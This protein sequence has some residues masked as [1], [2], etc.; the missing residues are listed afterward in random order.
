M[1]EQEPLTPEWAQ[2]VRDELEPGEELVWAVQPLPV[3]AGRTVRDALP[4][5][6]FGLFWLGFT[7]FGY[8]M[9][10]SHR[11][12]R[13][14]FDDDFE[15]NFQGDFFRAERE[16]RRQ[17]ASQVTAF[18][19]VPLV[20]A[21]GAGLVGVALLLSPL[22]MTLVR[23]RRQEQSCYALTTTRALVWEPVSGG[24]QLHSYAPHRLDSLKRIE[25]GD[26]SGDLVF[27]EYT[28]TYQVNVAP[29][30]S[31]PQYQTRQ[32]IGQRGFLNI[33]QVRQV[34]RLLRQTLLS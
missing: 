31:S 7:I 33:A 21:G 18:D 15:R 12:T 27:E 28:Y 32:G 20:I 19:V 17:E 5:M 9:W 14:Q 11:E 1:N 16:R 6:L 25:R 30:G 8:Y 22:W 3:S 13:K 2:R 26:G 29:A 4:W 10:Q 34:E 24:L 23:R